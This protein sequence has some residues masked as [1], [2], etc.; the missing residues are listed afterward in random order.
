VAVDRQITEVI[1]VSPGRDDSAVHV[2][3]LAP[4]QSAGG[5]WA[6]GV[7][8]DL[9]G[10]LPG[11]GERLGGPVHAVAGDAEWQQAI[12]TL[13]NSVGITY[14]SD[15]QVVEPVKSFDDW[16]GWLRV[17]GWVAGSVGL[18]MAAAAARVAASP[19]R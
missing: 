2:Y 10:R 15:V 6:T 18:L 12:A 17:K 1:H 8:V 19:G 4:V 11:P 5:Q 7:L 3:C 16:R 9:D 14:R 13:E